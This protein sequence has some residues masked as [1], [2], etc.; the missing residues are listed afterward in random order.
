MN[1][2]KPA[3]VP[4]PLDWLLDW[5]SP[6]DDPGPLPDSVGDSYLC[7]HNP[8]FAAVRTAALN[9]GYRFSSAD[10]P[11]W[12]DYN[13]FPLSTLDRILESRTIPYADNWSSLHRMA[14]TNA[15][16][17]LPMDVL[18][19]QLRQNHT[20]HEAAHGLA[21]D[22]LEGL[23]ADLRALCRTEKHCQ[24]IAALL[25]E[26]FANAVEVTGADFV[27]LPMADALFYR[28]NSYQRPRGDAIES[29]RLMEAERGPVRRFSLLVAAFFEA[30]HG[31]GDATPQALERIFESADPQ[32]SSERARDAA[33]I[34]F[35]LNTSFREIT[36][37]FYFQQKGCRAEFR[38]VAASGWLSAADHRAFFRHFL[39]CS[40]PLV[41][42]KRP[43]S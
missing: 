34:A 27:H 39:E 11:L 5:D 33:G 15:N 43:D 14:A 30:N 20:L 12:R 17:F 31:S 40:V 35:K 21:H 26:A 38:D 25:G 7:R 6:Q 3:G 19:N 16:A 1:A 13:F 23:K 24:V 41:L 18:S 36:T 22:T 42:N 37:P 8:V 2:A 29:L 28:L 4:V 10:T 9:R 32:G